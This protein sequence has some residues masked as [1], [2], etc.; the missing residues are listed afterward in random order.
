M[1]GWHCKPIESIID[2]R[3][4][5]FDFRSTAHRPGKDEKKEEEDF[6]SVVQ[7]LKKQVHK[8]GMSGE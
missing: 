8:H 3:G 5:R 7:N 6:A 2:I 1:K 4:S